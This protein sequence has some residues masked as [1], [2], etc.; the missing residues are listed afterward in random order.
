MQMSTV[1]KLSVFYFLGQCVPAVNNNSGEQ[2]S[3]GVGFNFKNILFQIFLLTAHL[4]QTIP[5]I[6]FKEKTY[7]KIN[8]D[9][10]FS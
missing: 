8:Y 1:P 2:C 4:T 3:D 7:Q 10:R 9:L 6:W 5:H